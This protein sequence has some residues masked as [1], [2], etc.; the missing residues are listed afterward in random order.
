MKLIYSELAL[1]DLRRL[2]EFV[3][4][5][6]PDLA[7]EI[8]LNIIQRIEKLVDFPLLGV[9]VRLA[10]DPDTVRDLIYDDYIVRYSCHS[11]MIVI[12]RLWHQREDRS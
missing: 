9:P 1:K 2:R 10:P 7:N 5:H 8:A 4:E 11:R 12:L 6:N 3:A